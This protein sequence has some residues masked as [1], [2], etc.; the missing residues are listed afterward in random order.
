MGNMSMH[1]CQSDPINTG[2][3]DHSGNT[4][5]QIHKKS[6]TALDSTGNSYKT[7]S[8]LTVTGVTTV[9][10]IASLLRGLYD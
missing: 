10:D 7:N 2:N 8:K 5:A 4:C 9:T 6:V 3:T 1:N